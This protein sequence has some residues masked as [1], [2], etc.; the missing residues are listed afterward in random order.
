VSRVVSADGRTDGHEEAI[1]AFRHFANAPKTLCHGILQGYSIE[2]FLCFSE[3]LLYYP[4]LT[5]IPQHNNGS[6]DKKLC[7]A[8]QTIYSVS[9][10]KLKFKW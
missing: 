9:D 7:M 8:T 10:F 6:W 1:V 3:N 4:H 2:D 5:L